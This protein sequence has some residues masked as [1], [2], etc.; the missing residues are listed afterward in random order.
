MSERHLNYVACKSCY[1][2]GLGRVRH[3]WRSVWGI[4][5]FIFR[6]LNF[7]FLKNNAIALVFTEVEY[8]RV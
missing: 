1:L 2:A 5:R 3:V 4:A 8:G 6:S 7:L